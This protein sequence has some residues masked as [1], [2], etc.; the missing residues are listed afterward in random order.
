MLTYSIGKSVQR[1][2]VTKCLHG[3]V[4]RWCTVLPLDS[5]NSETYSDQ[6]CDRS[7]A[8]HSDFG[9]GIKST[10]IPYVCWGEFTNCAGF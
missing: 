10:K 3:R 1:V 5:L 4:A 9:I 7:A 8:K 2:H 6:S